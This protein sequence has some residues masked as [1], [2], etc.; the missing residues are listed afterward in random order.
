MQQ[1]QQRMTGQ[2]V[3]IPGSRRAAGPALPGT[4]LPELLHDAR[5]V[6]TALGLYCDLLSEPG[7]L[8]E[9]HRHFVDELRLLS[10][11]TRSLVD[12]LGV[13]SDWKDVHTP[14][15]RR[16]ASRPAAGHSLA[17]LG[18]T[19]FLAGDLAVTALPGTGSYAL[20]HALPPVPMANLAAELRASRNLL[21]AMAGAGVSLGLKVEGG[22]LPVRLTGEELIRVLVNLVKNAAEAVPTPSR[23]EI[24]LRERRKPEPHLLLTVEDNGP[25]IPEPLRETVFTP[26]FTTKG[27]HANPSWS[28]AHRGLG[29]SISRAIVE[30]AGGSLTARQSAMGGARLDIEL[31]V[32]QP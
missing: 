4:T 7:V 9:P 30:A 26:R 31:P 5:S 19:G 11:A 21:E 10:A 23:I 27:D 12:K 1:L 13:L 3:G 17:P 6:V 20:E 25:G 28:A 24:R 29:L 14:V 32:R 15:P 2:Q 8:G 18:R 16:S 22:E